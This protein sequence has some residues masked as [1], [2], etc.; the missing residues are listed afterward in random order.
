MD[1]PRKR[2][3][4]CLRNLKSIA[5]NPFLS[6]F[7]GNQQENPA[8]CLK[9]S[10][11]EYPLHHFLF[12]ISILKR[13]SSTTWKHLQNSFQVLSLPLKFS[14]FLATKSG[15]RALIIDTFIFYA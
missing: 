9:W 15:Y 12:P 5:H 2:S 3:N 13:R 6:S 14:W 1:F 10:D 11:F 4:L 7:S 8:M